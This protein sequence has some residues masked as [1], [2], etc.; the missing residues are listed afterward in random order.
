ML[1]HSLQ[2]KLKNSQKNKFLH[3]YGQINKMLLKY[4]KLKFLITDLKIVLVQKKWDQLINQS[5]RNTFLKIIL[6]I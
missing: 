1:H 5:L 3:I 4:I 2:I 6:F